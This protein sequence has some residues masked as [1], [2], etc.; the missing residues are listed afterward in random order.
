M[1]VAL[2]VLEPAGGGTAPEEITAATIERWAPDADTA[3]RLRSHLRRAGCDVGPL[4]GLSFSVTAPDAT[5]EDA[6][7]PPTDDGWSTS[8]LPSE[9]AGAVRAVTTGPEI[10]FGPIEHPPDD[11]S[12]GK[13]FV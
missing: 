11:T 7:G 6:I 9:L 2:V 3:E 8:K 10:D 5:L 13:P 4:V 1:T 12:G